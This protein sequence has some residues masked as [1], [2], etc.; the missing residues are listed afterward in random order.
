MYESCLPCFSNVRDFHVFP[1]MFA[2]HIVC[3]CNAHLF[4][5]D[6]RCTNTYFACSHRHIARV[7]PGLDLAN[8]LRGFFF[9]ASNPL[10]VIYILKFISSIDITNA[11]HLPYPSLSDPASNHSSFAHLFSDPPRPLSF[12]FENSLWHFNSS[13]CEN[14][15]DL[16]KKGELTS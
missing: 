4:V 12:C 6:G 16:D 10:I 14:P 1:S 15:P 8:H 3:K 11:R 2:V 7:F 5:S 9:I 13:F